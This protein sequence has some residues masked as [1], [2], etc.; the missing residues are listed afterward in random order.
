MGRISWWCTEMW[1]GI[2]MGVFGT[3]AVLVLM[4]G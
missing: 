4:K 1:L 2:A 3:L